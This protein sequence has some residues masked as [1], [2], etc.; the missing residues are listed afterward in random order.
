MV[1][2]RLY[3]TCDNAINIRRKDQVQS[4]TELNPFL[5]L[6]LGPQSCTPTTLKT[7]V[8]Y[9]SSQNP[10]FGDV[11]IFDIKSH[12]TFQDNP[13]DENVNLLIQLFDRGDAGDDLLGEQIISVHQ[14]LTSTQAFV[15]TV[16]LIEP[17]DVS[18]N[19]KVQ[20]NIQFRPVMVGMLVVT[21]IECR[22]VMNLETNN[23]PVDT[24]LDLSVGNRVN[25]YNVMCDERGCINCGGRE[26]Y[27]HIDE[28]NW[29]NDLTIKL[30]EHSKSSNMI[31][32]GV[33]TVSFIS[34]MADPI[35]SH[36][37]RLSANLS[38]AS[39][40]G[41][42]SK[43]VG[44]LD[45]MLNFL[46]GGSLLV[47]VMRGQ[48]LR[49]LDIFRKINPYIKLTIQGRANVESKSSQSIKEG[50]ENPI[51]EEELSL[52][53]TDHHN[54]KIECY[55]DDNL[56]KNDQLVGKTELSLLPLFNKL[57]RSFI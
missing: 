11:I 17:G 47:K 49:D 54:I 40:Q 50:G 26:M 31:E 27:F 13:D 44:T 7:G 1:A 56:T 6:T 42:T 16:P 22:G 10:S 15:E 48:N 2:G 37:Q 43:P 57:I 24:T 9:Q 25:K 53:I 12:Y 14:H 34:Q 4:K 52:T 51:W 30:Y 33:E 18:S 46:H 35:N 55:D 5:K 21:L 36:T 38:S 45:A 23:I 29:F 39:K 19:S 28:T 32:I 41:H 20:L 8:Q 3:I